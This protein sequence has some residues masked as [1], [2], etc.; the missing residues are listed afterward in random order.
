M[1]R[2]RRDEWW[3]GGRSRDGKRTAELDCDCE[4]QD[5]K[6]LVMFHLSQALL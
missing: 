3:R 4:E 6:S 2:W 5:Q 1:Q